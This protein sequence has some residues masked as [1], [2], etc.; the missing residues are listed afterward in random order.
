MGVESPMLN[1][2]G[3]PEGAS[4]DFVF[5]TGKTFIVPGAKSFLQAF[6]PNAEIAPHLSETTKGIVS[7]ISRGANAVLHAVGI[8]SGKLD[9]Y[10]HPF[11]HPLSETDYS[12][13]AY[14][15]GDYVAKFNV[16]PSTGELKDPEGK[17]FEPNNENGLRFDVTA[18][19]RSNDAEFIFGVQVA[20]DSDKMPIEDASAEWPEDM[21]SF[22][23]VARIVIR[24]RRVFASPLGTSTVRVAV[25]G[26][27]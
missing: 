19:L 1:Q 23:P 13:T 5:Q 20:T 27:P 15:Y 3:A 12:Q 8:D 17:S 14:R 25:G 18:F 11:L 7:D 10:G 24:A 2:A 21:A 6:K 26:Q 4:Q 16:A 22:Q 9:F